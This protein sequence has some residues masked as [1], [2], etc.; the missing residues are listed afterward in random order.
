MSV[1][2]RVAIVTGAGGGL[3]REYALLLAKMGAKVVVNDYGGTLE[4]QSGTVTRAQQVADE[5]NADGG[6]AIADGHDVS[7]KNDT[8]EIVKRTISEFGRVDI[9]VNNAGISGKPSSH[10]ALDGPAFMRVMEIGVLGSQLMTS[11]VWSAMQSQGHGR[12][13]NI[14]SDAIMGF[15]AGGDCAYAGSKGA[16]FGITRDLGRFSPAHGIK[17]NAVLPSGT[18]RMG[19]LSDASKMITRTY[20]EASKCAPLVAALCSDECP[21]SGECI[22]TGAGRAARVTL[23]TFPGHVNETTAE[24]FLANWDTVMGEGKDV[25]FPSNTFDHV[26]YGVR[27]ATGQEVPD[28]ALGIVPT[29]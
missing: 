27:I 9:L 2:G 26:K 25:Y 14:S 23:A 8:I 10:D 3:G 29:S 1:Q 7:V 20:F 28:I 18:S 24:G 4:G 5:I 21:V 12:I 16:I 15:G 6:I 11:A 19:D 13:V 22:A 17:I